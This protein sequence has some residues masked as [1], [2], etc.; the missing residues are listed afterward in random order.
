[1]KVFQRQIVEVSFRFLPDG[2]NLVH[3]CIV[4]SNDE[5]NEEEED[6]KGQEFNTPKNMTLSSPSI[7]VAKLEDYLN[8]SSNYGMYSRN[9]QNVGSAAFQSR[10]EQEKAKISC[11]RTFV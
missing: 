5:I 2:K 4:L 8:D 3:P 1:M 10:I 7:P 6:N 11:P 9:V